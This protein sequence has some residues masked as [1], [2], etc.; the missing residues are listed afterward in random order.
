MYWYN[1]TT[2]VS[3]RATAPSTDEEAPDMLTGDPVPQG[4]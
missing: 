1:L 2:R 3:E 4:L